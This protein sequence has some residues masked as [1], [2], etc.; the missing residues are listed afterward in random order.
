MFLRIYAPFLF[1]KAY[2]I[3]ESDAENNRQV[4]RLTA[5]PLLSITMP[6]NSV[7]A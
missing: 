2:K 6:L 3:R 1:V 7:C 4:T 5:T